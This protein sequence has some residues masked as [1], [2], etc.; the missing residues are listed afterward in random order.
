ML[1]RMDL[2]SSLLKKIDDSVIYVGVIHELPLG[3]ITIK[4]YDS[5]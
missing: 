1:M 3:I 5:L 2:N 4:N